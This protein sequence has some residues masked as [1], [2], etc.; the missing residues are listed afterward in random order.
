[1]KKL[2]LAMLTLRSNLAGAGKTE[3]QIDDIILDLGL[4]IED[5]FKIYRAGNSQLLID[6]INATTLI[7]ASDKTQFITDLS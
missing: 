1:M 5:S 4:E 2:A 7:G 6:A 3:P